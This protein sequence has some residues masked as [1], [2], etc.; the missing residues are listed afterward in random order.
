M[1]KATEVVTAT[2]STQHKSVIQF[3]SNQACTVHYSS[4]SSSAKSSFA[5]SNQHTSL[6]KLSTM[7]SKLQTVLPGPARPFG[8][9]PRTY[10]GGRAR[11]TAPA[12]PHS[13]G[14]GSLSWCLWFFGD[15]DGRWIPRTGIKDGSSVRG[16]QA[17][18]SQKSLPSPQVERV[19]WVLNHKQGRA[20][21]LLPKT[22]IS[23]SWNVL[24][25]ALLYTLSL[26]DPQMLFSS[27]AV[28]SSTGRTTCGKAMAPR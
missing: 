1:N 27:S 17:H 16:T 2:P 5:V 6:L 23:Q 20:R 7:K 15:T 3:E 24:T 14:Y 13:R 18:F 21:K 12:L 11:R 10:C 28:I 8:R 19:C 26:A 4:I 9:L 22:C 25:V